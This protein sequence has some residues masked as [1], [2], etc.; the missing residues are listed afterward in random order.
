V[1]YVIGIDEAGR[2]ALAGPVAV[3]AVLLPSEHNNWKYW[4][5]TLSDSVPLELRDSKKLSEK[6]REEWFEKI[7]NKSKKWTPNVHF[8]V[9]MVDA[10]FIDS[11]GIV[12]AC[13]RAARVAVDGFGI[14]CKEAQVLCDAGLSV[15]EKWNQKS[16]VRGDESE[17]VIALASIVAKV[18][19]DR[20][21]KDISKKHPEYEFEKH[22]GYGTKLHCDA[23][24][25]KGPVGLIHRKTFI[26]RLT[27]D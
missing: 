21:M 20:L 7:Q 3:G 12:P 25:K 27:K 19:R 13:L 14:D 24:L 1:E 16:I 6:K 26:S 11:E 5:G 23:I 8:S 9:E 22:K 17:P 18:S 15:P 2:G 10:D 4:K